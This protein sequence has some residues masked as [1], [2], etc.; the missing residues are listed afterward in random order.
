MR[1]A[2]PDLR[3][4]HPLVD[5]L[6]ALYQ[7]D[8]FTRRLLG[9]FDDGLVPIF[10]SLDNLDAYFDPRLAPEDFLE[11]LAGWV[12]IALDESWPL[13]SRQ[14]LVGRAVDLYH[15]RG[16]AKGLT[17]QLELV[18]GGTIE[19]IENGGSAWSQNPESSLPGSADLNLV[20]RITGVS[21]RPAELKRLDEL[22]A[23]AKPAHIPHQI[24]VVRG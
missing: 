18:T 5:H 20:V 23:V 12:G 3:S 9:A 10:I 15:L 22:V 17:T 2:L 21:L 11:W 6:P 24:E 19:V 14:G 13:A 7:E 1:G 4:P 16:T 8:A